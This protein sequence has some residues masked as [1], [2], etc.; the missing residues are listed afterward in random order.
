MPVYLYTL[1]EDYM[2][3]GGDTDNLT[4]RLSAAGININDLEEYLP[5]Q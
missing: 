4:K 5:Q 1:I 2:T 3:Y